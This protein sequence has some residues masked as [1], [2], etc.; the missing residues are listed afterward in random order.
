MLTLPAFLQEEGVPLKI[1]RFLPLKIMYTL[2]II[3]QMAYK[4]GRL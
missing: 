2:R 3:K 1:S 4:G